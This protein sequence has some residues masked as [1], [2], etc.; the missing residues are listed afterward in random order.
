VPSS[1]VD[2]PSQTP[3]IRNPLGAIGNDAP[4]GKLRDD[5]EN[6]APEAQDPLAGMPEIDKWG[7]KGMRVLMNNYPD[8]N[9]LMNGM[10]PSALGLDLNSTE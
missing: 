7:I 10:E 6:R 4:A 5:K 2:G 9:A 8:Y 3:D 1:A